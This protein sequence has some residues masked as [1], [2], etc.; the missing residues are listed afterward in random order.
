MANDKILNGVSAA[1]MMEILRG[2]G[3]PAHDITKPNSGNKSKALSSL[4]HGVKFIVFLE[5]P[6]DANRFN[7]AEF[8]CGFTNQVSLKAVNEWNRTHNFL[9]A[10]VGDN[11]YLNLEMHLLASRVVLSAVE[12]HVHLWAAGVGEFVS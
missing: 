11:G 9:K 10:Y 6:A 2:V 12:H 7:V 4:A 1:D 8:W 3:L 5:S